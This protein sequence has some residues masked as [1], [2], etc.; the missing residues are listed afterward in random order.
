G[1]ALTGKAAT[2]QALLERL[3]KATVAHLAT[4]GY[5][6]EGQLTREQERARK[7]L[8]KGWKPTDAAT[9]PSGLGA[10]NPLGF[11]GLALV[12]ADEPGG[13]GIVTGLDL[14][15]LDLAKLRLCVLSACET[16]VGGWEDLAGTAALHRAFHLAGCRN[17][18]GSLWNVN[19][20]ATAALMSQ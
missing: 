4:H 10:R 7:G 5:F 17:V 16:G 19:D 1:A 2:A 3:P 11:V 8:E 9:P 18:V 14:L 12:A 6:D 20:A 15:E 13:K